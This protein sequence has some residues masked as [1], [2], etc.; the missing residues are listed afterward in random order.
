M[1][2]KLIVTYVV[3]N[4]RKTGP[5][6]QL[7]NLIRYF[8]R[9]IFEPVIITLSPEDNNLSMINDFQ[10]MNVHI[11]SLNY[12]KGVLPHRDHLNVALQKIKPDILHTHGFRPDILSALVNTNA[13][14]ITTIHCNPFEDYPKLYGMK[15]FAAAIY[16]VIALRKIPTRVACS[17]SLSETLKKFRLQTMVIPNSADLNIDVEML[18]LERSKIRKELG[19]RDKDFVF[20]YVGELIKRKNITFMIKIFNEIFKFENVYLMIVG[21]GRKTKYHNKA[22]K[23]IVFLGRQSNV[24]PFLIAADAFISAS[25]S[26]GL[27]TAVLEALSIGLPVFLSD[28]PAHREIFELATKSGIKIGKLFSLKS[29]LNALLELRN[30]M[31]DKYQVYDIVKFFENNFSAR[32]TSKKYQ[33]LYIR[34]VEKNDSL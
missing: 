33:E 31:E 10:N 6:V 19:F 9:D 8:D 12:P 13:K 18:K 26:E 32:L 1:Q 17:K 29:S 28:I 4:L 20:I 2:K 3:S 25:L 24:A 16:H 23:N 27:P 22:S 21:D 34:L 30:F 5:I 15:G 7:R 11:E 14:K